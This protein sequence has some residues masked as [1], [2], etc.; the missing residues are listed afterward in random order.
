MSESVLDRLLRYVK[1]DTQSSEDSETCPSTSKQFNLL[2]MLVKELQQIGLKDAEID[3]YGYVMATIP[4]N[5]PSNHKAAGKVPVVGLIS[6][7]DTSPSESGANVLPQIIDYKGGDIVLPGDTSVVIKDSE[8]P[9]LKHNIGK[10]IV[11]SDGT[12]LLGADDK[13]GLAIIMTAAE[14]LINNPK[15]LHGD[16]RIGFTPDEEIGAGTKF[17]DIKK[18]RAQFAYTVDGD[19]T[20]ELNKE[21]FSADQA[22]ITVH[23]RN[24]HPGSA[25][26][27]MVNSIRTIADIIA[28]MPKNIAPETTEG[29]EPYI[30]PHIVQGEESKSTLKILLRDFDTRGLTVLKQ[31]L[32]KIIAEVQPL[33][34]KAKIELNIIEQYRNM[35]D[36]L[37]NDPRL[38]G[39]LEEATKRAGLAPEWKPI[40]GGTD[41]SKLTAAGLPTPNIFTGGQNYH[42]KN[43][44]ASVYGMEKAVETVVN[45]VQLWAEKS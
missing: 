29:Y 18:F 34:P 25:K 3:K 37:G 42:C 28:R 40:R 15:L 38:L 41:G 17:F 20:G 33:H 36:G 16:I 24:I 30:H 27:I 8:N 22:V 21:T 11:T 14:T 2:N 44:W 19:T 13:A 31:K 45:L 43:E 7:V 1:I 26:G 23:G 12:T 35:K 9:E 10:K 4:S 32:E 39:C 5:I 6:H